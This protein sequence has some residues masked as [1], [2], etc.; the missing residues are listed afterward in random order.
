MQLYS[1]VPEAIAQKPVLK[2]LAG[3]L[4][5][6]LKEGKVFVLKSPSSEYEIRFGNNSS[7]FKID[8]LFMR[9]AHPEL[10]NFHMALVVK[11]SAF[12]GE[13]FSDT[14]R[15]DFE[16]FMTRLRNDGFTNSGEVFLWGRTA[17]RVESALLPR[18]TMDCT[19]DG[20]EREGLVYPVV[21]EAIED[22]WGDGPDGFDEMASPEASAY[23]RQVD[24][25]S[26]EDEVRGPVELSSVQ[27]NK[28][29]QS[30]VPEKIGQIRVVALKY[31]N[32]VIAYR[33][34]T[35][36]GAFD[37]RRDVAQWYGFGSFKTETFISL[38]SV[39]GLLMSSSEKRKQVCVPDV[40]DCQEDCQRL[41]SALFNS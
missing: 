4:G 28:I 31:Q 14:K 10:L 20:W 5:S 2:Y 22:G 12:W 9:K 13:L 26:E 33:F 24:S 18:C 23:D 38:E 7:W 3:A 8:D 41:V 21:E 36:V 16:L 25:F 11:D 32:Q 15:S 6:I 34:K 35:D 1:D 29:Q 30:I 39:N 40:S 27:F 37:M 17:Q 19:L